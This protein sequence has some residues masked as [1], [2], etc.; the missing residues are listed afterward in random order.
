MSTFCMVLR[1]TLFQAL[2]L[3]T[4]NITKCTNFVI[5]LFTNIAIH[6]IGGKFVGITW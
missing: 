1:A 2:K 6:R 3:T 5:S 4:R